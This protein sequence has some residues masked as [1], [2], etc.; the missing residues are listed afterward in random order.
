MNGTNPAKAPA[1]STPATSEGDTEREAG[2][3]PDTVPVVKSSGSDQEGSRTQR[4]K[5]RSPRKGGK[6][7]KNRP[8][9]RWKQSAFT[10]L[11][12]EVR[13]VAY[14]LPAL[15]VTW[16]WLEQGAAGGAIVGG[17]VYIVILICAFVLDSIHIKGGGK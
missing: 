11:A 12:K 10:N 9:F 1:P 4:K 2:E 13:R 7:S 15:L 3:R 16:G 6:P 5:A 17:I 14:I 8:G